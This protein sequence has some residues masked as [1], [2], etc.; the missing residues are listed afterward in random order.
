MHTV[1]QL[2]LAQRVHDALSHEGRAQ[3]CIVLDLGRQVRGHERAGEVA[4]LVRAGRQVRLA[5]ANDFMVRHVDHHEATDGDAVTQNHMGP[6]PRTLD[7]PHR[8]VHE[9]VRHIIVRGQVLLVGDIN[10]DQNHAQ[11]QRDG[12]QDPRGQTQELEKDNGVRP[13]HAQEVL[14]PQ[15]QHRLEKSPMRRPHR[16]ERLDRDRIRLGGIQRPVTPAAQEEDAQCH[17]ACTEC[18]GHE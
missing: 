10:G 7:V 16:D 14:I 2:H 17:Q 9:C 1:A 6:Q 3:R 4:G 13:R 18:Y 12:R 5:Q 11:R 15:T 8:E